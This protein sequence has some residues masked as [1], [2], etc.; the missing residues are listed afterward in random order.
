[1]VSQ[2]RTSVAVVGPKDSVQECIELSSKYKGLQLTP[3]TY[4]LELETQDIVRSISN[5]YDVMLFTGP[6]PYYQAVE[7]DEIKRIPSVYIPFNGSGLY[8]ALFQIKTTDL[9]RISIDTVSRNGIEKAYHELG[10]PSITHHVLE[11]DTALSVTEFVEFHKRLY[12]EGKVDVALTCL[13]SCYKE[14]KARG[15]PVIRIFPLKSVIEETLD[16]LLIMGESLLNK[17]SQIVVGCI[18][19]D[20]YQNNIV[21]KNSH[22][23]HR[24]QLELQQMILKYVEEIDGYF[25]QSSQ[26]EYLFFTTRS[27]FEKSSKH[28]T[29]SPLLEK[30]RRGMPVTISV[31]V[32]FAA[33]ANQAGSHARVALEKCKEYGGDTC[34]VVHENQSITGPIGRDS[35]LTVNS[36]SSDSKDLKGI[37]SAGINSY[38]FYR[39]MEAIRKT[40]GNFTANNVASYLNITM[41]STRRLL[42]KFENADII[43]K[44]GKESLHTKGKP[45]NVY[46]LSTEWESEV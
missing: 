44:V 7:V 38:T 6:I 32:G 12:D 46:T 9:S 11:Y 25:T 41:R 26:D 1:M 34:F 10:I 22:E 31:G 39:L 35:C 37:E 24:L 21:T 15:I 4:E 5:R 36:R 13:R 20:S 14:L 18:H 40:D 30:V 19:I 42:L 33:T 27:L 43:Q 45:R 3:F 2:K 17:E 29:T 23:I 28:F 8:R 16:K